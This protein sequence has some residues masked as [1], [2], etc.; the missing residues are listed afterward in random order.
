MQIT[1]QDISFAD[2]VA[3]LLEAHKSRVFSI[4]TAD[5]KQERGYAPI[6]FGRDFLQC[7]SAPDDRQNQRIYP[8]SAIIS[9]MPTG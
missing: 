6:F 3:T 8:F 5:G 2:G 4:V 7:Q 1:R 9:I